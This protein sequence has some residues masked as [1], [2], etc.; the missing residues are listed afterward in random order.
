MDKVILFI[1][2]SIPLIYISKHSLFEFKSHGFTRFWSWECIIALFVV[3]YEKWFTEP[4][5]LRQIVSWTLLLLSLWFVIEAVIRLRRARKPGIVRVEEKLYRFEKTTELVT[6]GIY[7]YIRHPMYSSLLF[8]T[9]GIWFKQP[10]VFTL[11]V[12]FMASWMLWLTARRDETLCLSVF[13]ESYREYM[14]R[15]KRLIPFIL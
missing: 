9:W 6:S 4:A 11:P 8:L 2:I 15:T 5:S 14:T 10:L 7:R 12:A 3:N 1:A 13:G